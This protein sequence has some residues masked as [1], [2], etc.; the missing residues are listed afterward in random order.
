M[1]R[2]RAQAA[3]PHEEALVW[4][5]TAIALQP[6]FADAFDNK[7]VALFH[8]HRFDELFAL[9]DRMMSLGISNEVTAWNVPL[10]DLLTGNFEAGWLGHQ[11]RSKLPSS[12][13]PRSP[14]PMW[15]GEE[16]IEGKTI[17]IAADQA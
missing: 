16:R 1:D 15:L 4:F 12:R 13:Y 17:L 3:S 14:Q 9:S 5:E 11:A 6:S 2:V 10:A 8:L 7:L